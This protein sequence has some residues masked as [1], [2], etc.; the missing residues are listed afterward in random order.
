MVR[1]MD[2]QSEIK[3]VSDKIGSPTFASDLAAMIF[4]LVQTNRFGLYH[5]CNCGQCS[6]Y[7]LAKKIAEILGKKNVRLVPVSSKEFV[8][9]APRGKLEALKNH[10]LEL[11]GM[12][13]MPAWEESL[14]AYL[15]AIK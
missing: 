10:N 15:R 9:S 13:D 1:L 6:R 2:A 8:L 5:V 3:V 4:R 11:L 7:E 14:A 12:N